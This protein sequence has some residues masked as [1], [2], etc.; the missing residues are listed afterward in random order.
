MLKIGKITT[1]MRHVKRYREIFDAMDETKKMPIKEIMDV[2]IDY[3]FDIEHHCIIEA[4]FGYRML[5]RSSIITTNALVDDVE[6][7]YGTVLP[8]ERKIADKQTLWHAYALAED[9]MYQCTENFYFGAELI[10][11]QIKEEWEEEEKRVLYVKKCVNEKIDYL[12][13]KLLVD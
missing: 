12:Y 3:T 11:I 13:R 1:A 8:T 7:S 9:L 10:Y 2:I 4:I 6:K 5:I